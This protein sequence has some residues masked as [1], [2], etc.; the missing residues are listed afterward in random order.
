MMFSF[1]FRLTDM[2]ASHALFFPLS[3]ALRA[4]LRHSQAAV[5]R[6]ADLVAPSTT[7][8]TP[9]SS[10][11]SPASLHPAYLAL[12]THLRKEISSLSLAFSGGKI[13]PAA[14]LA[15]LPKI[16]EAVDKLSAIVV[17]VIGGR[18]TCVRE[19]WKR[20]VVEVAQGVQALCGALVDG[21]ASGSLRSAASSPSSSSSSSPRYLVATSQCWS[22][23]DTRLLNASA[24]ESA[25]LVAALRPD[26]DR[27]SDAIE[28]EFKELLEQDE[29]FSEELEEEEIEE[30]EWSELQRE[31]SGAGALSEEERKRVKEVSSGGVCVVI[32]AEFRSD[33]DAAAACAF[34]APPTRV[35][36]G[37]CRRRRST[38]PRVHG[39]ISTVM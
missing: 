27:L 20:G 1:L 21:L 31:M 9:S 25:A 2:S 14:A 13:L 35:T 18:S 6:A 5:A 26:G 10:S 23:I 38:L 28:H 16:V 19:E 7:P 24:S 22:T 12:A 39:G 32:F 33:V 15:T 11:T 37:S 4:A 30:D 8:S 36:C 3:I 34:L 29:G 17:V